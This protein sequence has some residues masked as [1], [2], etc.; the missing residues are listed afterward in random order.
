MRYLS[1]NGEKCFCR[2]L[3][4][5]PESS[6]FLNYMNYYFKVVYKYTK[7]ELSLLILLTI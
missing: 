6:F 7:N 2:D 4:Q 5:S 3:Q 1:L